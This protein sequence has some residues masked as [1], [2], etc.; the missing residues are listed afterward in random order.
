MKTKII[1]AILL[2]ALFSVKAIAQENSN[3]VVQEALYR[4]QAEKLERER[5]A[6]QQRIE[7][8]RKARE[9]AQTPTPAPTP[10]PSST[11]KAKLEE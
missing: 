2:G 11:P 1:T 8:E 9:N 3:L 5:Q 4:A 6:E 10:T 7:A